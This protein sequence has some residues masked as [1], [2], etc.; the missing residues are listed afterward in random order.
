MSAPAFEIQGGW[1]RVDGYR[2]RMSAICR[3][4]QECDDSCWIYQTGNSNGRGFKHAGLA[5]A[6]DAWFEG[7]GEVK[8]MIGSGVR[9][10][11][12]SNEREF[13]VDDNGNGYYYNATSKGLA[14]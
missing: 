7:E 5:E 9:I 6:L 12:D 4:S 1:L 8:R 2:I 14:T 3:Y 11:N 10:D 13:V